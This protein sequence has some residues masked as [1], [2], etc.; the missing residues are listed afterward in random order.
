[1]QLPVLPSVSEARFAEAAVSTT[2]GPADTV[3][4]DQDDAPLRVTLFGDQCCPEPGEP[5]AHHEQIGGHPA[6][7]CTAWGGTVRI[8]EPKRGGGCLRQRAADGVW[9]S[10]SASPTL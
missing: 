5:P 1:M 6:R 10:H 9:D 4:L 2:R 7:D 3:S 8:V